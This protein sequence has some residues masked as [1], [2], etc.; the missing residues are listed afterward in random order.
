MGLT[1]AD[2]ATEAINGDCV[3]SDSYFTDAAGRAHEVQSLSCRRSG[4]WTQ[5]SA[6][7]SNSRIARDS[8]LCLQSTAGQAN[9]SV[10]SKFERPITRMYTRDWSCLAYPVLSTSPSKAR[11]FQP[12]RRPAWTPNRILASQRLVGKGHLWDVAFARFPI[13]DRCSSG[14]RRIS[15]RLETWHP[16]YCL[17]SSGAQGCAVRLHSSFPNC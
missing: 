9:G 5:D 16:P 12:S 4:N 3:Q 15:G 2:I 1:P 17:R 7:R 11:F 14:A 6:S 13:A 10:I 8:G